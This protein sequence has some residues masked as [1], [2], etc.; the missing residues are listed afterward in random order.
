MTAML[1]MSRALGAAQV[2]AYSGSEYASGGE[3]Y[4]AERDTSE[5]E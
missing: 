4:Y 2:K 5:G 3:S 1:T